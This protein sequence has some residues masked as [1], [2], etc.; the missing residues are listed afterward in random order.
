MNKS[1]E[2]QPLGAFMA[3]KRVAWCQSAGRHARPEK[4]FQKIGIKERGLP[5]RNV[6]T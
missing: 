1:C 6:K 2:I 3:V 4:G 5:C